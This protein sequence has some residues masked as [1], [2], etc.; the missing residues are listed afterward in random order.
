MRS[1]I[2][3]AY[4]LQDQELPIFYYIT[5]YFPKIVK[6]IL[7]EIP[8]YYQILARETKLKKLAIK[9]EMTEIKI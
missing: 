4:K 9:K 5:K 7:E 3:T 2:S 1:E 6:G 8:Y